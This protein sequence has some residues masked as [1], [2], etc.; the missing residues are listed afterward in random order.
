MDGRTL[1]T[2][3]DQYVDQL[4]QR[5]RLAA[6]GAAAFGVF[7]F[8]VTF[9]FSCTLASFFLAWILG[10]TANHL[11]AIGALIVLAFCFVYVLVPRHELERAEAMEEPAI[12]GK[13]IQKPD[14][15][16]VQYRPS[17]SRYS[18]SMAHG[19]VFY[20]LFNLDFAKALFAMFIDFMTSGPRW[21]HEGLK[22]LRS[23]ERLNDVDRR[24]CAAVIAYLYRRG[25]RAS[26]EEIARSVPGVNPP[27]TFPQLAMIDGVLHLVTEPPGFALSEE[28][29]KELDRIAVSGGVGA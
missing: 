18:V 4:R 23:A 22:F 15:W 21:I 3:F 14:R 25:H 8:F 17:L 20:A 26:Y 6:L 13:T 27:V 10:I 24:T 16:A 12:G 29:Q 2:W 11:V 28:L 7:W 1:W 9:V 5:K 19:G